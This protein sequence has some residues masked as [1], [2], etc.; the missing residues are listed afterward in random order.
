MKKNKL[1]ENAI[2]RL[3]R[4]EKKESPYHLFGQYDITVG[5]YKEWFIKVMQEYAE[6]FHAI[7]MVK[8]LPNMG[9]IRE[10]IMKAFRAGEE[11]ETL[12]ADYFDNA[13]KFADRILESYF[14][15]KENNDP[16]N[17]H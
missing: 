3:V 6:H 5:S 14:K 9:Q 15:D 10:L 13:S 12:G 2:R 11:C 8:E 17:N 1:L 7:E 16:T 4:K